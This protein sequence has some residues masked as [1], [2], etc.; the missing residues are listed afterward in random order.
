MFL[1]N[2]NGNHRKVTMIIWQL[3]LRLAPR[4]TSNLLENGVGCCQVDLTSTLFGNGVSGNSEVRDLLHLHHHNN[5][6]TPTTGNRLLY[7][8]R[9]GLHYP[10]P[11]NMPHHQPQPLCQECAIKEG[12][13]DT[14]EFNW[15][16]IQKNDVKRPTNLHS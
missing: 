11:E 16:R 3:I 8:Y 1:P 9:R 12:E 13:I 7:L 15:S 10:G 4:L 2:G 6:T 14:Y 5:R